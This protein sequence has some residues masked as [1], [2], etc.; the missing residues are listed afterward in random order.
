MGKRKAERLFAV[1]LAA[2]AVGVAGAGV[3]PVRTSQI[4]DAITLENGKVKGVFRLAEGRVEQTFYALRGEDWLPVANSLRAVPRDRDGSGTTPR[5]LPSAL[6]DSSVDPTN[7]LLVSEVVREMRVLQHSAG[8]AKILLRGSRNGA[9]IEETVELRRGDSFFHIEAQARLAGQKPGLEYLLLPFEFQAEGKPDVTRAPGFKPTEDSVIGDRVFFAPVVYAQKDSLFAA[10]IPDVEVIN[11]CVV[12]AKGARQHPDSDSFRVPIPPESVS[13]PTV[14]DLV[15]PKREAGRAVFAYGLMDEIVHQHVWFEH[16]NVPGAMVRE[17]SANVIRIGMDLLLL[18]DAP[19][20]RGYQAVAAHQ[21][22]RFG[23]K[24]FASPRPQAM[25]YADYALAFYP[26]NFSYQGYEV[27]RSQS[28]QHRHVAGHDMDVWQQWEEAGEPVGGMRLHAPQWYHLIA[29]LGWWNNVCD[30]TGLYYWGNKLGKANW[31]DHAQRMVNLSLSA[32]QNQGLFPGMYDLQQHCWRGSLWRPPLDGYDPNR[33]D[34]YWNWK[35]GAYQTASASVTAGYLMQYRRT[36]EANERILP[37]VRRYGD[38]LLAH[39]QTNGCV[40]AW[41]DPQLRPLPSMKWNPDGG[42]HA[43]V[44]SELYLATGEAKYLEGAKRAA[45][46]I[47]DQVLPQQRWGDFEAFYSCATTP[48]TYFDERTGQWPCNTMSMSWALQGFLAL[49]EATGAR[50]YL[51]AAEATADYAS[52][53]QAVWAPHYVVTAFPFGGFTSQLGDAEWLDQRTHRFADPFVRIGLL[54]RRQDLVERGIAAARSCLTLGNDPRHVANGIY[55]YPDF[56]FGLGPENVDHE[57]FPQRPLASGPSWNT[58]GGLAGVAHVCARLG[59][60]Y[61]DCASGIAV[62][63]DGLKV[64]ACKNDKGTLRL[65]L[66]DQLAKLPLPFDQPFTVTL[67]VTGLSKPAAP[68]RL[69]VSWTSPKN[70]TV[71][72]AT[73]KAGIR[74][75]VGSQEQRLELQVRPDGKIA[76]VE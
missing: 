36:C 21:W 2:S 45:Q 73:P 43:W 71:R 33:K 46:V 54:A 69:C 72:A 76:A 74:L 48:E 16:R 28:L 25:P 22:R 35:D 61:V 6:Y 41:F 49:Y 9:T 32:P 66:E 30:A 44:L 51:D 26:P 7:R 39:I 67:R 60:V 14:L 5:S 62:G 53:F 70:G 20:Y 12:Y 50:N 52:L 40:P 10:L 29:N 11:R 65:E 59:G 34:S 42:A 8:E 3:P 23:S 57:G 1:L 18:A 55:S 31:V 15:L 68:D 38:F 19:R 4:N 13:M 64:S 37:Y 24:W 75:N 56:P 27:S 63:V 17:L 58:V 47:Q